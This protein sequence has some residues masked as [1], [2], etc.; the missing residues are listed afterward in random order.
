[1]Q[2]FVHGSHHNACEHATYL[3]N[4]REDSSS[5]CDF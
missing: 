4:G 1:M 5:F 2:A 3:P